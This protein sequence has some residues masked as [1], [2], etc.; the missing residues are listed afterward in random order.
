MEIKKSKKTVFPESKEPVKKTS[1]VEKT[2]KLTFRENRKFDLHV[3]REMITFRGRETKLVPK[4][5]L[6]HKDFQVVKNYFIQKGV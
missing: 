1:L 3:G 2:V 4:D 5:W 6:N